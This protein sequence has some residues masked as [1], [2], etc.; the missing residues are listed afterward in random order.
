MSGL[1]P[2]VGLLVVYAH[3]SDLEGFSV[4][5][6]HRISL[7]QD[8]LH[9]SYKCRIVPNGRSNLTQDSFVTA[10]GVIIDLAEGVFRSSWVDFDDIRTVTIGEYR[11]NQED[12]IFPLVC[13]FQ[14][15]IEK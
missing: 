14:E 5:T 10:V 7:S 9:V 8:D 15:L 13:C 11:T 6:S 12:S 4:L 1:D 3:L 2:G